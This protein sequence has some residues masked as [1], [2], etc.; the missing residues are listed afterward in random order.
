MESEFRGLPT[1]ESTNSISESPNPFS[2][3]FFR[4]CN[5]DEYMYS[6]PV[7]ARIST[8]NIKYFYLF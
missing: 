4:A 7:A 8:G 3:D 5:N 6:G 1:S 2:C